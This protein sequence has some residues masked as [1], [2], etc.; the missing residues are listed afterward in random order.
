MW[1][2]SWGI[3]GTIPHRTSDSPSVGLCQSCSWV[4]PKVTQSP[5]SRVVAVPSTVM[6]SDPLEHVDEDRC[7]VEPVGPAGS[8][9][10]S[11]PREHHL[12]VT[13]VFD[14]GAAAPN[15]TA[16]VLLGP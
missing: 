9:A 15:L 2:C 14:R 6:A 3:G 10:R 7:G 4:A 1:N 5:V 16:E 12:H 8:A 11:H 13:F